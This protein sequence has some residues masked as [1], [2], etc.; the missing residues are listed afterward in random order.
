VEG[1]N[2]LRADLSEPGHL[3]MT[4]TPETHAPRRV[5]WDKALSATAVTSYFLMLEQRVAELSQ[6]IARHASHGEVIDMAGWLSSFTIDFM[7][8]FSWGSVFTSM[9]D[10][11][12]GAAQ[13]ELIKIFRSGVIATE[14]LTT[15]PW[16]RSILHALPSSDTKTMIDRSSAVLKDRKARGA[17]GEVRHPDLFHYLVSLP[18]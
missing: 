16:T 4:M 8:D 9:H 3:L 5:G 6:H 2:I 18:A 12:A 10:R 14:V 15:I 13:D 11:D 1:Y 7:G 17:S